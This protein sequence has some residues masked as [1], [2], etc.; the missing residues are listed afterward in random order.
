MRVMSMVGDTAKG[1]GSLVGI[2][3]GTE[4]PRYATEDRTHGLEIRRYGPRI[5]AETVVPAGPGSARDTGFRRLAGYIFGGNTGNS[6]IAMTAPVSEAAE[7][8]DS[9]RIRFFMPSERT[10]DSLPTPENREVR[11]VELPGETVAVLRFSGDRDAA[12]VTAHTADLRRALA[13]TEWAPTGE[14]VAWFYDPP[15]TLPFRR[16]NEV[17][18]PVERRP[19]PGDRPGSGSAAG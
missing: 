6:K 16:R 11:L 2:R 19:G 10:M 5:A 13:D 4:E 7:P 15:W 17:V 1:L 8:D 12:A 9:R 18:V 14:P 3:T